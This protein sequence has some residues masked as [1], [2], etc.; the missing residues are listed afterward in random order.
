ME[1]I[2]FFKDDNVEFLIYFQITSP[3]MLLPKHNCTINQETLIQIKHKSKFSFDE[4]WKYVVAIKSFLTL[5]YFSEPHIQE[6]K[7]FQDENMIVLFYVGQNKGNFKDKRHRKNFLFTYDLIKND[8]NLIFNKWKELNVLIE[9]VINVLQESFSNRNL[10]IENKFLNLM[11]AIETFHRRRRNNEK[12]SK[13]IFNSRLEQIF[14]LCLPE[15]RDWLKERISYKN[16]PDLDYR[17]TNLFKEID[18]SLIKYLFKNERD[19]ILDSKYSRNY[20]THYGKELE[21]KVLRGKELYYLTERL[22]IFLL[23]LLLQET[24]IGKDKVNIIV[25][26]ASI[27]LFN[28]L[29]YEE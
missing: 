15:H 1:P 24:E 14:D 16:E 28:N 20:Y 18:T 19:I 10:I 23:I 5:A 21:K 29:I 11:Q 7:L 17:L 2:S 13:E 26:D 3:F 4:Y 22:K 12:E 9:P 8:F 25:K 27:F 6:I